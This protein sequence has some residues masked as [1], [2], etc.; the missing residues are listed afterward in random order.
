[1]GEKETEL[2]FQFEDL[3]LEMGKRENYSSPNI[4]EA[5]SPLVFPLETT[6]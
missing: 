5:S 2:I 3:L 4:M 1:M 6:L